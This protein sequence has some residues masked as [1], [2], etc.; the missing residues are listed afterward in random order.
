[1]VEAGRAA[2]ACRYNDMNTI[3]KTSDKTP[4]YHSS[5]VAGHK[6]TEKHGVEDIVIIRMLP[7]VRDRLPEVGW[8]GHDSDSSVLV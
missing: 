3:G 1:M 7:I 4:L 8:T 6:L 5:G 2:C